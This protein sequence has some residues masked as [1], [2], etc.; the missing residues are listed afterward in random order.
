MW[1]PS[2]VKPFQ[3]HNALKKFKLQPQ[4]LNTQRVLWYFLVPPL[5][6]PSEQAEKLK[7]HEM[8]EGWMKDEWIMMKDERWRMKDE[9]WRMK[10][11]WWRIKDDDFKLFR[12]FA[13]RLMDGWTFSLIQRK[14]WIWHYFPLA[15]LPHK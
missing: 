5:E 13:H 7:S 8:K 3:L 6:M 15:P 11:E 9:W 4:A 2:I 10:D 1:T 14:K 12:I